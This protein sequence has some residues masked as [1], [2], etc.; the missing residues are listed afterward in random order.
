M[1]LDYKEIGRRV[2]RRRK[3]LKL[4]QEF[5][6]ELVDVSPQYISYIEHACAECRTVSWI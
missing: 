3:Q 2:A 5:L 6:A 4:T 1:E